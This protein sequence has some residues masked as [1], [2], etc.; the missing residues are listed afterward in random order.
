MVNK[1]TGEQKVLSFEDFRIGFKTEFYRAYQNYIRHETEKNVFLPEFMRK[2]VTE[3]DFLLSLIW[4]FN[5]YSSSEW[6]IAKIN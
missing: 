2:S 1:R 4:N 3:N 5:H 6:Y